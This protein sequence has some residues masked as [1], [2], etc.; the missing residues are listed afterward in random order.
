MDIVITPKKLIGAVQVIPS[1]SQAHRVLICS[2]FADQET[3]VICTDT[4]QDI[5]ATASCLRSL[6]ARI[7]RTC[8]G[9]LVTPIRSTPQQAVLHCGESGSTLRF[10]LPVVG[11]LGVDARFVTAGRLSERPLSPLWEEMERMGCILRWEDNGVLR[12]TGKLHPGHY[13]I[14]GTVSSQFIS[15]LYFALSLIPNTSS[16]EITGNM[17]SAPYIELT[18]D[19]LS[20]FGVS[21]DN[22]QIIG[23]F[24]FTTPKQITIEGDWS[25]GAFFHT[26]NFLQNEIEILG[27]CDTSKQG[28][29]QITEALIQLK[30]CA[31]INASDIPD[32]VPILSIAA[33]CNK[34]ATF[35]NTK[36]LRLKE[37]D[38]VQAIID[39]LSAFGI[40]A[41]ADENTLTVSPGKFQGGTINTYN[42]HRIA[43]SAG[44]AAT[45]AEGPVIICGAEC[46]AKSYPKF[47]EEYSRL[48]GIYEQ[49]LR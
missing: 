3:A 4:N 17:E 16:L 39:M 10:L 14:S 12:C 5:E 30:D 20:Q 43:M 13:R 46:V 1:K 23:Q 32:L 26:A 11:A 28:D 40:K 44:I 47:W 21:V 22:E 45:A 33:A 49:Y 7:Q 18:K 2:A 25:N 15:G 27:L 8:D 29:R 37:S 48:G 41:E 6:G 36:R 35:I 9:Y 42:D 31:T 19:A 24:P 38:R 34:G